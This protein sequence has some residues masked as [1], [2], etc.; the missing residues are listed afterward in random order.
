MLSYRLGTFNDFHWGFK[1]VV[2]IHQT[3]HLLNIYW[4][5]ER[6]RNAFALYSLPTMCIIYYLEIKGLPES[7]EVLI[8]V[9]QTLVSSGHNLLHTQRLPRIL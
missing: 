9:A 6:K 2:L 1:P 8:L 5:S 4:K 3:P 7:S